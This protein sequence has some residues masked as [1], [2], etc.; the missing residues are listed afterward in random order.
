MR[1]KN[2]FVI[3]AGASALA[4]AFGVG[5]AVGQSAP[6]ETKGMNVSPPTAIELE[7]E[8]D[9]VA[10]RQLRLRVVTFEPGGQIAVHSHKGR[11]AVVHMLQGTLMEHVE[12]KG[13]FVRQAGE[14]WSEGKD[15]THWVENTSGQPAV[16]VAVDVFKP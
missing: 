4:L 7:S 3:A 12:G 9:G 8:I 1:S 5:V 15:V 10:G 16:L 6:T 2:S 13:T 11:P 14:S